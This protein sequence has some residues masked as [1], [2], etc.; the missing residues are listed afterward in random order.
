LIKT[1]LNPLKQVSEEGAN[2]AESILTLVLPLISVAVS[3]FTFWKGNELSRKLQKSTQEHEKQ[4]QEQDQR[5]QD[6]INQL[7]QE[8]NERI[9]KLR[10]TLE[11]ERSKEIEELKHGLESQRSKEHARMDYEYDARK[12]LYQEYEP[13]IFQLQELGESSYRRIH[14]L[15]RTARQGNLNP[16]SGWLSNP[17]SYYS[18]NTIYRL[19]APVA[20]FRL[21]QRRLTLFDLDLESSFRDQYF[22]AKALYHTF[23]K[24][25]DLAAEEPKLEYNPHN[26]TVAQKHRHPEKYKMQGIVLGIVD[27]MTEAMIQEEDPIQNQKVYRIIS[28]GEFQKRYF[29]S[30]VSDPFKHASNLFLDFNPETKPILWRI[31]LT[32]ASIYRTIFSLRKNKGIGIKPSFLEIMPNEEREKF[33]WNNTRAPD[34]KN[35][36]K[37]EGHLKTAQKYIETALNIGI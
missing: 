31:L 12:R 18:V 5:H 36:E 14:G 7:Q 3:V 2:I 33:G 15:A 32:Q 19:L 9:E 16:G 8:H 25:F 20:V 30:A 26:S 28:F 17:L 34:P 10:H 29:S 13:L 4:L 35:G 1:G 37:L 22:L 27:S 6:R 23:S 24:D 21:M 11:S